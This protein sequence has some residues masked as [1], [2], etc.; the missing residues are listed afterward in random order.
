MAQFSGSTS[1]AARH[2]R[3][4]QPKSGNRS[5][6]Q[7]TSKPTTRRLGGLNAQ[8]CPALSAEPKHKSDLEAITQNV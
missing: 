1:E 4:T 3:L 8:I 2:R 5:K 7:K 6:N